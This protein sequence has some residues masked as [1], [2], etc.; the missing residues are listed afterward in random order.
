VFEA[1]RGNALDILHDIAAIAAVETEHLQPSMLS[2]LHR[3]PAP[4]QPTPGWLL[5][6]M[7]KRRQVAALRLPRQHLM[8]A[9][10]AA[11][12]L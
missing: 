9:G 2:Y 12:A 8:A 1:A 4:G 5:Q 3:P 7:L 11:A 10:A 6:Q